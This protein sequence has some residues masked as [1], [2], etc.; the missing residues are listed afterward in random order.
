[1]LSIGETAPGVRDEQVLHQAT[2]ERRV[3]LTNDKDFAALAF[4]Q[5]MVS[6]GI[7]LIPMLRARARPKG[8]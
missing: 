6:A 3:L 1:M 7:V 8:E 5:R 2:V 4:L